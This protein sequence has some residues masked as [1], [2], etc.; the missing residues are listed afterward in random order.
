MADLG[1]FDGQTLLARTPGTTS[2]ISTAVDSVLIQAIAPSLETLLEYFSK[3]IDN[4]RRILL[5][6]FPWCLHSRSHR[7]MQKRDCRI[8]VQI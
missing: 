6:P 3:L 1:L 2:R 8:R 7:P 5:E 4:G